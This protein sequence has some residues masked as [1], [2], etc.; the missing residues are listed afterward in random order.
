MGTFCDYFDSLLGWEPFRAAQFGIQHFA[1]IGLN[2]K[3]ANDPRCRAVLDVL[4][5]YLVKD[6]VVAVG[7][8]GYDS[9]TPEEDE[10]FAAQ[11]A[12]AARARPARRSCT[13]R[14]ATSSPARVAPSTSSRESGLEPGRVARRPPQRDDRGTGRRQRLLD[15]LLDLPGH[16]DGRRTAWSRSCGSTAPS[17]CSSTRPPTGAAATPCSTVRTAE[18]MLAAGFDEDDVDRVLW[19]NPVEFY[20][21]SGRLELEDVERMP[22]AHRSAPPSRARPPARRSRATRCCAAPG[23]ADVRLRHADG[24]T[25][26]VAYCTNVHAGDDLDE[27]AR[28]ARPFAL[29]VRHHL[30]TDLLGVG[31]W[32]AAPARPRARRRRRRHRPAARRA[33]AGAGWRR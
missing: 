32:L 27:V 28:A 1:T 14:T 9:M 18:A 12:L 16:Q 2:P 20:G 8:L 7:E 11:L 31:L 30:G 29:P 25:V 22:S 26:H 21:Q 4:P 5:R 24:T 15:G 13:P 33:V 23:T 10:V 17:G 3:E 19:R 6:R